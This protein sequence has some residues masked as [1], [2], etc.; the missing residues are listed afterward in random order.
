MDPIHLTPPPEFSSPRLTMRHYLLQDAGMYLRM[1][2]ENWEHLYE[3]LPENVEKAQNEADIEAV[4]RWLDTEREKK[5]IF[6]WGIW[7]KTTGQYVGEVYLANADWH[8]PSI[9][10]GYFLVKAATGK[11]YATEAART[12]IQIAF[13][14]L[15]VIRVDLQVRSDN[16]ASQRVAEGCGFRYEGCQRLRHRK[17]SGELVDRLWYGLLKEQ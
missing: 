9:E 12:A 13:E 2:R 1:V 3:F 6:V 4:F 10:L 8:V 16:P 11:G 14:D 7:E 5:N 17:K 15:H